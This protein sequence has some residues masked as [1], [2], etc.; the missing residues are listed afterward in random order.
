METKDSEVSKT[1]KLVDYYDRLSDMPN[2]IIH[3]IFSSLLIIELVQASVLSKRL[4]Y[5][6]TSMPYLNFE[7]SKMWN[8][9]SWKGKFSLVMKCVLSPRDKSSDI[10][11]LRVSSPDLC[12]GSLMYWWLYMAHTRN[13]QVINLDIAVPHRVWY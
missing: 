8:M 3:N 11:T 5:L 10:E 7:K 6:W 13:V 1:T 12:D 4:R 9:N 2:E